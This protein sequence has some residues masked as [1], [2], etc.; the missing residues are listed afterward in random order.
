MPLYE[1]ECSSCGALF[2]RLRQMDDAD[3][4]C[5]RCSSAHVARRI[6][7]F[8][9]TTSTRTGTSTTATGGCACGGACACR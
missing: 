9:A 2:E 4:N 6:S 5:P 1:Y 8:A 3:P 7:M